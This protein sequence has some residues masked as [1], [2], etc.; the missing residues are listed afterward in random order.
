MGFSSLH[1]VLVSS[2]YVVSLGFGVDSRDITFNIPNLNWPGLCIKLRSFYT[3]IEFLSE[4]W[5]VL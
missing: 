4:V 3:W 2:Q 1:R 5:L